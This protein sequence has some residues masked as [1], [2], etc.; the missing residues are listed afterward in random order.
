MSRLERLLR[1]SAVA[2]ELSF[3][4]AARRLN[5]D[6]TW[7]S[8]QIQQ[9]EAEL[10]F[11]L[12]HR[13]TRKVE[14]TTKG[15]VLYEQVREITATVDR[16]LD[17]VRALGRQELSLTLGVQPY[18]FWLPAR[19]KLIAQFESGHP[20]VALSL[21]NNYT[22]R[23]ISKLR[24]WVLD[25]ALIPGPLRPLPDMEAL[26]ISE[27]PLRLLVPLEDR[28]ARKPSVS[29]QDLVG[30]KIVT[31]DQ[32]LNGSM[33]E[34]R[35]GAMIDAGAI[36]V[37]GAESGLGL[38]H[39]AKTNRLILPAFDWPHADKTL[40]Q[41]FVSVALEPGF[42]TVTHWLVRRREENSRPVEWMWGLAQDL[43]R[44]VD[45]PDSHRRPK[46]PKGVRP[47]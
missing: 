39:T 47:R 29:L 36:P 46:A 24:R 23:L 11:A 15:G 5:V 33:Y 37:L 18:T 20:G 7:L 17:T 6:P 43:N 44:K 21:T 31:F 2:E 1:F 12:F 28:L 9:L 25:L 41:D 4:R 8:R 45:S 34:G 19:Q 40:L 3:S 26:C 30:K 27:Q 42:P 35:Y 32:R 16:T 10:G 38:Y 14:L 22:P 13:T